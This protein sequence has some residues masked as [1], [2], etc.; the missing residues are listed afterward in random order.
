MGRGRDAQA[1][2]SVA[3]QDASVQAWEN[4]HASHINVV[5]GMECHTTSLMNSDNEWNEILKGHPIFSLPKSFRDPITETDT[6]LEL[7]TNTL[8]RFVKADPLDDGPTP[9]GRRQTMVLKDA[10]LIVAAGKEIRMTSL[11]DTKLGQS[12]RKTYKVLSET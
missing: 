12:T 3:H 6:S 1:Y 4:I 9:S 7:S 2:R 5:I 11:G 8:P 10:D